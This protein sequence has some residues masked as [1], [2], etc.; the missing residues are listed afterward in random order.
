MAL[1]YVVVLAA[2]LIGMGIGALWV[3]PVMFAHEWMRLLGF[4]GR[5]VDQ[6]T[7]IPK[8]SFSPPVA[9][10]VEFVM[11]LITSY[12]LAA[13]SLTLGISSLA[14]A[15]AL[16]F[17]LWLGFQL[18]VLFTTVLFERRPMK[19]FLINASHRLV[20]LLVMSLVV[21]LWH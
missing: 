13:F 14:G 21:G 16:G 3:S 5:D 4:S 12:V 19:L 7:N 8:S 20:V 10:L 9:M 2:A 15:L 6:K 1:N 17:W 11:L 18:P